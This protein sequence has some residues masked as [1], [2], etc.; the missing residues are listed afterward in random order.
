MIIDESFRSRNYPDMSYWWST[1]SYTGILCYTYYT[2]LSLVV[3]GRKL[4]EWLYSSLIASIAGIFYLLSQ[5]GFLLGSTMGSSMFALFGYQVASALI[6][7]TPML[8]TVFVL[9][10]IVATAGSENHCLEEPAL[11]P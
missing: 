3:H 4:I 10:P 1:S 5:I 7:S 11:P 6:A 8:F 2:G 9:L